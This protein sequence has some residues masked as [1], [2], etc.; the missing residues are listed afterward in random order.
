MYFIHR[1]MRE[2]GTFIWVKVGYGKP[3]LGEDCVLDRN[4]WYHVLVCTVSNRSVTVQIHAWGVLQ[5]Y[6]FFFIS[7]TSTEYKIQYWQ[8]E[9]L[10]QNFLSGCKICIASCSLTRANL[11]LVWKRKEFL[12]LAAANSY[13]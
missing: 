13:C 11:C 2:I 12:L 6:C 8:I 1:I 3:W 9:P 7:V 10:V 4:Q 5:N